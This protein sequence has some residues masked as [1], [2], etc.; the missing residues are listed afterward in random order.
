MAIVKMKKAQIVALQSEK[1]AI[2]KTLQKFG[3]LHVI[4]LEEQLADEN[5]H[6]LIADS[7]HDKVN[8]L[9]AKL[10]QVKYS[11]DFLSKH[12]KAKKTTAPKRMQISEGEYQEYLNNN[13]KLEDI[14]AQCREID[15]KHAELKNRE[16]KLLNLI[17]QLQPW[18]PLKADFC[19][20]RATSQANIATGYVLTKF[21]EAF[22]S[23]FLNVGE[24]VFYEEINSGR[25]NSY[26]LIVYHKEVEEKVMQ[27][28]KQYGWSKVAFNDLCGTAEQNIHSLNSEIESL[29]GE[30]SALND[31]AQSLMEHKTYLNVLLDV[32][33]IERD[34]AA[35]VE[36]FSRTEQTFMI[37]GWV[38]AKASKELED[39][40]KSVTSNYYLVIEDPAEDEMPP[41]FLNNPSVVQPVEFITEQYSLPSPKGIDPNTIMAPFFVGF[42]G[43]MV[44]DAAYGVV[45]ALISGLFLWKAKPEGGLKKIMGIMF[46]GGISTLLWGAAFGGWLGGLIPAKPWLFDPLKEPFKMLGL[47]LGLGIVHL[48]VGIGLQAYRNIRDGNL[49]DAI[50]DQGFWYSLLTGVMLMLLPATAVVGKYMAIVGAAGMILFAGRAHKNPIRRLFSGVMSLYNI[51]GFLGDVLSYLRLFALGLATGVIGAVVNSMSLML[52]GSIIG[53]FFM[54]VFLIAGHTFNMGINVLGAYVHSSRLQYVEFFGKFYEGEGKPFNPFRMKARFIEQK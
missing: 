34:K 16:T 25:E 41:V 50:Y 18:K 44:S 3:G 8:Q 1:H 51:T 4:G 46:W 53:Y 30:R 37:S 24:L 48:Y 47:C 42:F 49:L 36:S 6:E 10:S 40:L 27:I 22:K 54:T 12:D 5:Y 9:E 28:Q 2:I 11:L 43:M 14:F 31:A 26:V 38:Q 29:Q 33:G 13:Q 15:L 23:D 45:L 39:R 7:E 17:Q 20:I 52:G 35:I 32:F 19:D 21:A